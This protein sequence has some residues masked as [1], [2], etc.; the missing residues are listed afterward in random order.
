MRKPDFISLVVSF[1]FSRHLFSFVNF[2]HFFFPSV[3][4]VCGKINIVLYNRR[5]NFTVTN[6]AIARSSDTRYIPQ[7]TSFSLARWINY[8]SLDP[9]GYGTV[10]STF[11]EV[12]K[13]KNVLKGLLTHLTSK[14]FTFSLISA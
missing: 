6:N 11:Y 8:I 13:F 9:K 10:Y 4:V 12:E 2:H 3:I 7:M 5:V 1:R 14:L